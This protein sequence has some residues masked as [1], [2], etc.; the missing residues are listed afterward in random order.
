MKDELSAILS[1]FLIHVIIF[2]SVNIVRKQNFVL[3]TY[4]IAKRIIKQY[5]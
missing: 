4:K 2:L 1:P 5:N 3:F